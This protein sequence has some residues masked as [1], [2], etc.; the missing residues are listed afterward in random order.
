MASEKQE[1]G[2]VEIETG[3]G[4]V[5]AD[6]GMANAGE[7]KVKANLVRRI[8]R[9]I[10][11]R[12]LTQAQA[13]KLLGLHQPDV[14]KLLRGHFRSYSMEKLLTLLVKL[15]Q[16]VEIVVKPKPARRARK[17]EMTVLTV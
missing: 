4:N 6:L 11:A 9:I 16:D 2:S 8:Q 12:G 5:F 14:S 1:D 7:H 15:D 10:T 17:S 13:A 3:S